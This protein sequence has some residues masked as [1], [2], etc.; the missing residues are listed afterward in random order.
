MLFHGPFPKKKT[1]GVVA[2]RGL[3]EFLYWFYQGDP[4]AHHKLK[5]HHHHHFS[6]SFINFGNCV[7]IIYTPNKLIDVILLFFFIVVN[8]FLGVPTI[9]LYQKNH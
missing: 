9:C 1:V 5:A 6:H 4:T 8:N 2:A 7:E 3:F